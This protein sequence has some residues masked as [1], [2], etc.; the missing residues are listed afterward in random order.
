MRDDVKVRNAVVMKQS[1]G[2]PMINLFL[3]TKA[4]DLIAFRIFHKR[5]EALAWLK[6]EVERFEVGPK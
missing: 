1:Y 4:T 6:R 5:D 2:V 3:R